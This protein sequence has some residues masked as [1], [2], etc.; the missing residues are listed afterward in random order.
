MATPWSFLTR[1]QTQCQRSV[2]AECGVSCDSCCG[3][4]QSESMNTHNFG[5][6]RVRMVSE[7]QHQ[8]YEVTHLGKAGSCSDR[9]LLLVLE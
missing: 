5:G 6:K 2:H 7:R 4:K 1:T 9:Q 3:R 8:Q